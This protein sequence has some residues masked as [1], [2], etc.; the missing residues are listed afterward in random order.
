MQILF[1]NYCS[2]EF[3]VKKSVKMSSSE[4]KLSAGAPPHKK[5]SE[6]ESPPSSSSSESD[7]FKKPTSSG[8]ES[9]ESE[10]PTS[11]TKTSKKSRKKKSSV[12][13]TSLAKRKRNLIKK[14]AVA[15][16]EMEDYEPR[17]KR[18]RNRDS[19][20]ALACTLQYRHKIRGN[21]KI[22]KDQISAMY[23]SNKM[24]KDQVVVSEKEYN[25][26]KC[27][28]KYLKAIRANKQTLRIGLE[29]VQEMTNQL[30]SCKLSKK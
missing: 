11:S 21:M 1:Q 19:K 3:D 14:A 15:K 30:N 17:E 16:A 26:Q 13:N 9:D 20:K 10:K 8:S 18:H 28:S 25:D 22:W 24:M 4:P 23:R 12:Y 29:C 7:E 27:Y 6:S 5:I 2:F